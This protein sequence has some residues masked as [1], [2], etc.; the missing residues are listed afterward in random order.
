MYLLLGK[1]F[2]LRVL[3]VLKFPVSLSRYSIHVFNV[4]FLCVYL[5]FQSKDDQNKCIIIKDQK[6]LNPFISQ[7][8]N[9]DA[10]WGI[11]DIYEK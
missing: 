8:R 1:I 6:I 2:N 4:V 7:T 9:R 5:A 10:S 3:Y 11:I